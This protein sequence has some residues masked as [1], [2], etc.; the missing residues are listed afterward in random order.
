MSGVDEQRTVEASKK[1]Q[2]ERQMTLEE[3]IEHC[4]SKGLSLV[5]AS[6][7]KPQEPASDDE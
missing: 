5:R 4:R 3:L 1:P 7:M 6:E 2:D